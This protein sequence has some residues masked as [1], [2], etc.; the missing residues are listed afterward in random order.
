MREPILQTLLLS[1]AA[2]LERAATSMLEADAKQRK[3][4]AEHPQ[5]YDEDFHAAGIAQHIRGIYTQIESLIKQALEL[6]DGK[7]P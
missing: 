7:L 1:K 4:K 3:L 6:T 2:D 5:A